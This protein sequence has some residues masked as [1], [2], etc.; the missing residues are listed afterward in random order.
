MQETDAGYNCRKQ[1]QEEFLKQLKGELQ[2]GQPHGR[3]TD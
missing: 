1:L 3:G 2:E